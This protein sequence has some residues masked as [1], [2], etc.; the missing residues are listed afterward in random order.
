MELCNLYH[1][2]PSLAD[3]SG[4]PSWYAELDL[5]THGLDT[6]AVV[7]AIEDYSGRFARTLRADHRRFSGHVRPPNHEPR[8]SRRVA[9]C[10]SPCRVTTVTRHGRDRAKNSA[11]GLRSLAG[12]IIKKVLSP[13]IIIVVD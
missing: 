2:S 11:R 7:T 4:A 10:R 12:W 1:L 9:S 3:P 6:S 13:W 5:K 8:E